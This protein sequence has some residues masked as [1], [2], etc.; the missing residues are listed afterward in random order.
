MEN[1]EDLFFKIINEISSSYKIRDK[2]NWLDIGCGNGDLTYL[3]NSQ[4]I[5]CIG[6]DVEFKEGLNIDKLVD[7]KKVRLIETINNSRR[8]LEN[9]N[10][11]YRW[12]CPSESITFSFSSSVI[13][14]V[15][16]IE[17][18]ISENSRVIKKGGLSIHYFPSKYALFEAHTGIPFGGI[19]INLRYYQLMTKLRLCNG[20]FRDHIE[21][22]KYMQS[23]T[24]YIN[25]K[26]LINQFEKEKL[27]FLEERNDL[28][29]KTK[30]GVFMK[31]LSRSKFFC[32][33]FGL[34]RSR[35]L[36]F[37]KN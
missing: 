12:P 1:D 32:F 4:N 27:Y 35:L 11:K 6:I 20:N 29:V 19:F 23:S 28:I 31:Y 14:H 13:E 2:D 16:N 10:S 30:G 5:N 7:E 24:N 8:E 15:I 33:I 26:A 9:F 25:K 22:F 37:I 18:F 36:I 34:L 21:S 17:E 3:I